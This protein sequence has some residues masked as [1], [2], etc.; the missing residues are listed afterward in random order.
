MNIKYFQQINQLSFLF[1]ALPQA[2][3]DATTTVVEATHVVIIWHR[4]P[5]DNGTLTYA[6]DC[7][8]CRSNEDKQCNELC[9]RQVR[10]SP[11]KENITGVNVT[12]NGLSASSFFLFRVYSVNEFNQQEKDRNNWKF[13]EV[14]VETKGEVK[15]E[16][17]QKSVTLA[18]SIPEIPGKNDK[19]FSK[20]SFGKMNVLIGNGY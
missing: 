18:N 4:S 1:L 20:L 17:Q 7:F 13:A 11:R 16:R 10:Y 19:I 15:R 9:D 12:L 14:Y 3:L 8:R 6:V 2:P 5:D